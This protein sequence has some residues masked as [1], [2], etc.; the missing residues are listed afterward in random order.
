MENIIQAGIDAEYLR[1]DSLKI[2]PNQYATDKMKHKLTACNVLLYPL[3]VNFIK[4]Y[5]NV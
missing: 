4:V 1:L 2:V 3:Q 5:E